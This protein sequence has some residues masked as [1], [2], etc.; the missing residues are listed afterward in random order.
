MERLSGDKTI[1]TLRRN[2]EI[3]ETLALVGHVKGKI[4]NKK[5]KEEKVRGM[6]PFTM[7][8]GFNVPRSTRV[9]IVKPSWLRAR[10][11][12]W[13]EGNGSRGSDIPRYRSSGIAG[14]NQRRTGSN[15]SGAWPH[16]TRRITTHGLER[17]T[18]GDKF[19]YVLAVSWK[20]SNS[21][22]SSI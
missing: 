13:M 3:Q 20:M 9:G 4:E 12:M 22:W 14:R 8:R 7:L 1:V 11:R 15:F 18:M 16:L 6:V 19:F 17:P 10:A 2:G 5:E 21:V